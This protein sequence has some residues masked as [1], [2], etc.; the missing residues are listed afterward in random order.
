MHGHNYYS[1]LVVIVVLGHNLHVVSHQV[2]RVEP[3][4]ELADQVDVTTLLHV[5]QE[6]CEG[7]TW[8]WACHN[9]AWAASTPLMLC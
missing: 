1:L 4:T 9:Q 6:G 7:Q 5:L 2:H 8:G 3:N